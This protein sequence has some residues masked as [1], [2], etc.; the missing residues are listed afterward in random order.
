MPLR[1]PSAAS[2]S[3]GTR[4][5]ATLTGRASPP[6]QGRYSLTLAPIRVASLR[7]PSHEA[8]TLAHFVLG[9]N[10]DLI[11]EQQDAERADCHQ[12]RHPIACC[13]HD[14]IVVHTTT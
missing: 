6:P 3:L 14:R 8:A 4:G 13:E 2:A 7:R 5:R 1:A 10:A 11:A 9:E 12:P